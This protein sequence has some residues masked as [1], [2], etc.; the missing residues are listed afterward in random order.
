MAES[1]RPTVDHRCINLDAV[2]CQPIFCI[3]RDA[4]V[5]TIPPHRAQNNFEG[6]TDD[7]RA[8]YQTSRASK[9]EHFFK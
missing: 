2:L 4:C 7:F 1:M 8:N 5:T 6:K 3:V 9:S